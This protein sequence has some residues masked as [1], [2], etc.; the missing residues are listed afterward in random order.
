[1]VKHIDPRAGFTVIALPRINVTRY[2]IDSGMRSLGS[3]MQAAQRRAISRQHDIIVFFDVN[4][5][6][7]RVHEDRDNNGQVDTGE[8]IRALPIGDKVVL[9]RGNAPAHP[10][11][12][13]PVTFTKQISNIPAVTF[14]RNGAASEQGGVYMTSRRALNTGAHPEDTRLL[15]I[16]RAT[17][18]V[19]W[20]RYTGSA[21]EREF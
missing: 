2:Q 18:R 6:I 5:Q 1:M 11:G 8:L 10:I 12:A 9:G 4:N 13:G 14:H 15:E 7:V 16:E 17:G 21:W 20:H 3:G 19:S